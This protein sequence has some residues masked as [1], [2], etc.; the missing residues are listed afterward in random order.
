[1]MIYC[2]KIE[3][4]NSIFCELFL[5]R[6]TLRLQLF[7]MHFLLW[8][9]MV[10]LRILKREAKARLAQLLCLR[11]ILLV[12][13]LWF[14]INICTCMKFK[15]SIF[16]YIFRMRIFLPTNLPQIFG[17]AE[18]QNF[19]LERFISCACLMQS[20]KFVNFFGDI[21]RLVLFICW[22]IYKGF[23]VNESYI[24]LVKAMW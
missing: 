7:S 16:Q 4:K 21:V 24:K 18:V 3:L 8:I 13:H 5:C 22:K 9:L 20:L 1:M 19:L 23:L 2:F 12:H 15:N 10:D 6:Q 11:C 17:L 14:W